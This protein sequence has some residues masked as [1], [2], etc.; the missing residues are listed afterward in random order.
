MKILILL[1][2]LIWSPVYSRTLEGGVSNQRGFIG[3][4]TYERTIE[5]VYIDSPAWRAL[6]KK[7]D[8][9]LEV[10]GDK[11]NQ[12]IGEPYSEVHLLIKRPLTG[13]GYIMFHV[14]LVR[15]P[16][17]EIKKRQFEYLRDH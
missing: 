15:V 11:Y 7:G 2:I 4:R 6:L 16:E 10:D 14:Y 8:K 5:R 12:I 17:S 3:V 9:I 1:F 13:N